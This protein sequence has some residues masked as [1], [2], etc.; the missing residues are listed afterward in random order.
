MLAGLRGEQQFGGLGAQDFAAVGEQGLE[1]AQVIGC[2][3]EQSAAACVE[4]PEAGVVN[5]RGDGREFACVGSLVQLGKAK[6]VSVM[7]SGAN[8]SAANQSASERPDAA[9]T[10][11]PAQ[12]MP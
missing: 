4:F 8:I 5:R 7:P 6:P 1:E 10:I 12:S 3:A 11:R 9:S 2:T